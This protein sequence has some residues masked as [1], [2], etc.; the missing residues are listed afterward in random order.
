MCVL[1]KDAVY[2]F[3]ETS[4]VTFEE[5]SRERIQAYVATGSPMDKAGAYGIQDSGFVKEIIGSYRNVMGLPAERL[6][7][8]LQCVMRNS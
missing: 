5:L 6:Q 4:E 8:V 7:E 3:C 2:L 1:C